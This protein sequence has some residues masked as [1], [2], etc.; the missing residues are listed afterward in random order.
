LKSGLGKVWNWREITITTDGHVRGGVLDKEKEQN[1]DILSHYNPDNRTLVFWCKIEKEDEWDNIDMIE[2]ANPS[3][4]YPAFRSL[5]STIEQEIMDMP[6]NMDYYSEFLTKRCDFPIGDKEMEVATW[7]DIMETNRPLPDMTGWS[8][9]GGIDYSKTNDFVGC[10]LLFHKNGMYYGLQHTFICSHSRDLPGIKFPWKEEVRNGN[11]TLVN[12]VEVPAS[13]VAEWFEEK[14]AQYQI[15][16]IA[17]DRFRYSL[18]MR[19]LREVG[20]D[21]QNKGNVKLIKPLNI[22][23]AAP[24]INTIFL[25]HKLIV[26]DVPI[27]RWYVNNTK[28]IEKNGNITYGKIEPLYRKTDGFMAF[29]AAMTEMNDEPEQVT[30]NVPLS[31][32]TY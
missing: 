9:V 3:I 6:Y 2:K 15:K 1:K 22:I 24:I 8:C 28:R 7:N 11:A 13:M 27:W 10:F 16:T 31:V 20:F 23:D 29:V 17:I 21:A 26:G 25:E 30:Y 5:K 4:N 19:A 12:E 18:M 14:A 32:F